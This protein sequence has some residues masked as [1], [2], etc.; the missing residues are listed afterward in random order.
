MK[1]NVE[2]F[3][4]EYTNSNNNDDRSLED[5]LVKQRIIITNISNYCR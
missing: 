1:N 4:D 5:K 2:A 3:R